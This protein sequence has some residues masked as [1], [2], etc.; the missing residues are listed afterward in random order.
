[1]ENRLEEC[2]DNRA[3]QIAEFNKELGRRLASLDRGDKV[4]PATVWAH[5]ERKSK[6]RRQQNRR[7]LDSD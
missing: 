5:L 4:D 6:E 7:S 1:M 2:E 3:A